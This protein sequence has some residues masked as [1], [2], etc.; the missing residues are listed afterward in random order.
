[1][2]ARDERCHLGLLPAGGGPSLR[3]QSRRAHD[4]A[5]YRTA[6]GVVRP[7]RNGR[8]T[9]FAS[10]R[11]RR[12]TLPCHRKPPVP[13]RSKALTLCSALVSLFHPQITQIDLI[14]SV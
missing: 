13:H 3:W 11:S 10:N 1:M 8:P 5:S 7:D 12:F 4:C 6:K 9:L 2:E 14:K